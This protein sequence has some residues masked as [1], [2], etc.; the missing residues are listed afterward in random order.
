M[1]EVGDDIVIQVVTD[2][3]FIYKLVRKM[4]M[5]KRPHLWWTPCTTYCIDLMLEKIGK[6][7]QHKIALIK[8]KKVTTINLVIINYYYHYY[9][10]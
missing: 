3:A 2:N 6:L 9:Y 7:P 4:L 8:A 5:D 10:Y 1:E